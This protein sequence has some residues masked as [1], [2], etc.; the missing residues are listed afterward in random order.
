[1]L[2]GQAEA[3][4]EDMLADLILD[5]TISAQREIKRGRVVCGTCGTR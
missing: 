3:V 2:T 1:M 4:F 5:V